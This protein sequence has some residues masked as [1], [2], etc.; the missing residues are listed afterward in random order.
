MQNFLEIL[1][2][3]QNTAIALGFFDGLHKGHRKVISLA[4]NEKQNG[5][6]P[7]CF[8]FLQ[9]PKSVIFGTPAN[10]VMT[11]EDKLKTL[12][13]LGIE[14]TYRADFKQIMNMS[15]DDFVEKILIKTL[16]AKKL[17]CGF[18]YRFGKNGNGDVELLKQLCLKNNIEVCVVPSEQDN[19]DVVS[20]TLIR[21]LIE[22]GNVKRANAILCTKFGFSS[23]IEHGK[24]LGRELGTPTINQ[25]LNPDLVVPKFGVYAS[26]VT[27]ENGKVYC[28]VTNIGIKPTVGGTVAL[29]E[30]WMPEYDGDEIYGQKADIRL[31]DFIRP[32]KK[33]NG[34]VELKDA[35]ISNGRTALKIFYDIL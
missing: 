16:N 11:V 35:I 20:S 32:E 3:Q 28:G 13:T 18:N 7:V 31:L 21:E 1:P 34:I 2:E 8:T 5:L 10:A 14:H 17:F 25:P 9:S 12:E 27:L 22:N 15:A 24:R 33:F 6:I 29:C 23:V 26:A 19:G 4:V 30:T